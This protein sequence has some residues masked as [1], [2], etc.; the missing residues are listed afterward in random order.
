[1]EKGQGIFMNLEQK[2]QILTDAAKY[3][4]SCSSSGSNRQNRGG[5]GNGAS[6][7]ICHSWSD[8][9]RCVSL[10]KIL[11]SNVCA[12]DCIYCLNRKSSD[13][14]R[15]TFEPRELAELTIEFYKRNYIEGLFL[16]S[17]VVKDPNHTMELMIQTV[18]ILRNEMNF[19]G[20]IHMKA[21]PGASSILL[22]QAGFLADRMS[23]N[24]ELPSAESLTLLAPDKT[25][26]S[27]LTPMGYIQKKREDMERRGKQRLFN[28]A[29]Q[30]TQMMVGASREN[31]RHI[32]KLASS[33]YKNFQLK[34]V[35]YSAY[36]PIV[37]DSR[38]P[39]LPSP[40]LWRE[41][42]L[43]QADWL[44]RFYGFKAEELLTTGDWNFTIDYDPKTQWAL[45]SM[46]LFP[47]EINR[48][49]YEMLLRVPGIGMISANR[50]VAAR[51]TQTLRWE[52]LPKLGI[53]MKRA[54]HFI[55]CEGKYKGAYGFTEPLIRQA[56]AESTGKYKRKRQPMDQISLFE[57]SPPNVPLLSNLLSARTGQL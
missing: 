51:R 11:Q 15:A 26:E 41:N 43:Y 18:Q 13:L 2:L 32:V 9:G 21:I 39:A 12:Y 4:A 54:Q 57:E 31:D 45:E 7:G 1:M 37:E 29:G 44:L 46:H 14:P 19:N 56:L 38:L 27:I 16:S 55:T 33:L 52:H 20:Y 10:L 24:I 40:P 53:V 47:L 3:D 28:P 6:M 17:A 25:R 34:R 8:D 23:V 35:Y 5:V 42:R 22:D 49:E 30:S 36:V 50:I 48:A